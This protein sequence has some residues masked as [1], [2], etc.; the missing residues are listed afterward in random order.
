MAKISFSKLKLNKETEVTNVTIG[1]AIVEVKHYVPMSE[2][3]LILDTIIQEAFD[4]NFINKA[5]ADALLH[6]YMIMCYTNITFTKKEK[7]SLLDTYDLME[8]NG[9]ID[10]L[11]SAIP[12]AEYNAFIAYCKDVMSDYDKYKNSI[13]GIAEQIL[14]E[15]PGKLQDINSLM[16]GFNPQDLKVLQDVVSNFGGSPA[17]VAETVLGQD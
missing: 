1:D 2:K 8:K 5:K 6:I 16:N 14:S 17:A 4:Y 15:L 12:E 11:V 7:D 10:A 13:M 3:L 9:V